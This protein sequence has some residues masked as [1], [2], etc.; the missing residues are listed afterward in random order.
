MVYP[1]HIKQEIARA[2]RGLERSLDVE[3]KAGEFYRLAGLANLDREKIITAMLALRGMKEL[4]DM[5]LGQAVSLIGI[6]QADEQAILDVY[7]KQGG[8]FVV[9]RSSSIL[10]DTREEMMAGRFKSYP[11]IRSDKLLFESILKCLAYYWVEMGE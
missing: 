1:D 8:V 2:Y 4:S 9:V 10:E 7:N 6:D 11:Y 5:T 3:E